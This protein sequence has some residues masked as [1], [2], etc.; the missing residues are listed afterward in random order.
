MFYSSSIA[1]CILL[2]VY[3][4]IVIIS[5]DTEDI[6]S[7]KHFLKVEF[8]TNDLGQLRHFVGIEVAYSG[9]SISLSQRKYVLD[10]LVEVG[11]AGVK[12]ADS[13]IDP[14]IRLDLE[15]GDLLY[16]LAQY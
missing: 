8:Y 4:D 7:L 1:S 5:S 14:T 2:V 9:C 12:P 6:Q 11:Y 16:N 3:V 15:H 13:P 10:I